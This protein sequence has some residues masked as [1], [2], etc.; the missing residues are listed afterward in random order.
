MNRTIYRVIQVVLIL[1]FYMIPYLFL[2][3]SRGFEL[4]T[5][6]V[7]LTLIIGIIS[8]ICLWRR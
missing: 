2:V 6:W 5:Y 3:K 8:L 4:F 1:C 7:L